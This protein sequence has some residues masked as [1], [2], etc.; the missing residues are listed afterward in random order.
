MVKQ[1]DLRPP[2]GANKRR[3]RLGRGDASGKGSYSGRGRKGAGARA[4]GAA[5]RG[6]QGWQIPWIKALPKKRGFTNPNPHDFAVVN[7]KRLEERFQAGEEVTPSRMV[8]VGLVRGLRLPVKVLGDGELTKALTVTA[9][10]FSAGAL[11]KLQEAG[12]S[13]QIVDG[14]PWTGKRERRAGH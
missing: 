13:A 5:H 2:K 12:G 14:L 10:S 3:K 9:H 6:F 4:G 1:H 11:Q 8:E 7:L